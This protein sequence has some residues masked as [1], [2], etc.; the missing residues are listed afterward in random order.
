MASCSSET[1]TIQ[2]FLAKAL[3]IRS[4]Q[5]RQRLLKVAHGHATQVKHRQQRIEAAGPPRPPR[6][7][8]GGEAG[9]LP[10]PHGSAVADLVPFH[11]ERPD[12]G[13]IP[14][15]LSTDLRPIA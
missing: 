5:R 9:P 3:G 1:R 12:P 4:Q 8:V 14:T 7:D 10:R 2:V 15:A 13:L 6:Q 11:G